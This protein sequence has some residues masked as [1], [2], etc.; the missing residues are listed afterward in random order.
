MRAAY[1]DDLQ[2]NTRVGDGA[3]L[4]GL[5]SAVCTLVMEIEAKFVW[6]LS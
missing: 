1:I 4:I 5:D 6:L 2:W 3:L